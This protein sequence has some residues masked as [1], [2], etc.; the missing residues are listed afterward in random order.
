[1]REAIIKASEGHRAFGKLLKRVF[2]SDE[3]L[4]VERDGYPVAV[5]LSF[6]EYEKLKRDHAIATFDM[7]SHSIGLAIDEQSITEEELSA[8]VEAARHEVYSERY[9]T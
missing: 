7:L 8:D 3:H 9:G 2:R 4:I 6:Q 5:L 1:M